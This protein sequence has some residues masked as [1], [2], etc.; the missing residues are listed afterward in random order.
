MPIDMHAQYQHVVKNNFAHQIAYYESRLE[1]LSEYS[2]NFLIFDN[3]IKNDQKLLK[4]S[5]K[6]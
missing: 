5:Q 6:F 3:F 1:N 2:R 4:F